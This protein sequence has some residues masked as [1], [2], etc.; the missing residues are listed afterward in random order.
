MIDHKNISSYARVRDAPPVSNL[1]AI[2]SWI[3]ALLLC[4]ID[5][6]IVWNFC[7]L[8]IDRVKHARLTGESYAAGFSYGYASLIGLVLALAGIL[9]APRRFNSPASTSLLKR[10]AP[11]RMHFLINL[12]TILVLI[13]S[14]P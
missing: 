11:S 7:I 2:L 5:L 10:V 12:V 1:R 6:I 4:V 3:A 9:V 13:L 8:W 14:Q